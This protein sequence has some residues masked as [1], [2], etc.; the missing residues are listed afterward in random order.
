M[1]KN[2]NKIIYILIAILIL[3]LFGIGIYFYFNSNKLTIYE[4]NWI[5]DNASSMQLINI[6]II[7]DAEVFGNSGEGV[8]YNFLNDFEEKYALKLNKVPFEYGDVKQGVSLTIK[9]SLDKNDI[10]FYKDHFVLVSLKYE[11][12]NSIDDLE[13]KTVGILAG[14]LPYVSSYMNNNKMTF[15]TYENKDDL[16]ASLT[17]SSYAIVPLHLY[18]D[19]LLHNNLKVVYHFS[20]INI[21]Y[22]LS[23]ANDT[24]S[25]ILR[26]FYANWEKKKNEYYNDNLFY[27]LTKGLGLSATD[28]DVIRSV[29]YDYGFVNNSPYEVISNG[30]YGGIAAVYL[31]GFADL[32]DI[33][34]N[35]TRYHNYNRFIKTISKDKVDMYF[36]YYNINNDFV[37]TES[38]IIANYVVVANIKNDVVINSINSLVGKRVYVNDNSKLY[39]YLKSLNGIDVKVYKDNNELKKFNNKDEIIFIDKNIYDYYRNHG[40]NNYSVRYQD[41]LKLNYGFYVKKDSSMNT[42]Y[43]LLNLYMNITDSAKVINEGIYNH[44]KAVKSGIVLS[45]IAKNFIYFLIIGLLVVSILSKKRKKVKIAKKIK[46]EDKIKFID[47]LTLLKNR[48]YLNENIKDWNNN[49]IYPQSIILIDLNKVKDINDTKGYEEGDKQIKAAANVLINNQLDKSEVIRTDGNEFVVYTVG[50]SQKQVTN[51]IHK[52]NREFKNLPYEYGAEFSYSMILDDLKTIEDALNDATKL[53][54]DQKDLTNEEDKD[55]S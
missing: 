10:S 37:S 21:Y 43:K 6:N 17:D 12:N 48:N 54:H 18:L 24:L 46:K 28:I 55:K 2:K 33:D 29:S 5:D 31:K 36:G 38:G 53:L 22:V 14:E 44:D 16:I 4:K 15:K 52:L 34:F 19:E 13:G 7:N 3:V 41:S 49:T 9:K 1:K 51:Y 20:D 8:F 27:V 39:S 47:Q 25:S 32:V 11:I 42:R 30:N 40:L 50:Y 35:F 26:K 45:T 23:T